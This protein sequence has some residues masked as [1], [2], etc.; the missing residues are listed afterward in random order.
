MEEHLL[1]DNLDTMYGTEY[2][3]EQVSQDALNISCQVQ[4]SGQSGC[5]TPPEDS[6]NSIETASDLTSPFSRENAKVLL[7]HKGHHVVTFIVKYQ[8]DVKVFLDLCY[9]GSNHSSILCW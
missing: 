1:V 2:T 7:I 9:C 3:I 6:V 5:S 8:E 4:L